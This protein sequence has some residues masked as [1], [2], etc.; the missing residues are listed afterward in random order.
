M[1]STQKALRWGVEQR[2]EFIEFHLFW[3][4]GVNRSDIINFFGVSVPQ[5]SNDLSRYQEIAP[6]NIVYDLSEK[7]YLATKSFKPKFLDPDSD[8]YLSYLRHMAEGLLEPHE[9]WISVVPET[10]TLPL[11]HRNIVPEILK[12]VLEAVRHKRSLKVLYQSLSVERPKPAWREI[13]PHAFAHDGFRWHVRAFCHIDSHFKDFLLPR[14]LETG[15]FGEALAETSDDA[16]W[17]E[18][19]VVSLKPH[20]DLTVE[21]QYVIARDYGMSKQRV[22]IEVRKALLYYFLKQLGL[23]FNE[24]A[25]P[26]REQHVVL[27]N[28]KNV[29]HALEQT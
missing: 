11:P 15:D 14:I 25:R 20:P 18:T 29:K 5:A 27:A 19:I 3:E 1:A 22:S 12:P 9:T 28:S 6:R 21:Q 2:L 16:A 10:A 26:A 8:R 13:S 23:D 24:H 7:R 17:H 4:G